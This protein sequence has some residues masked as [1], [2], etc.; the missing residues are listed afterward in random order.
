[1]EIFR[2]LGTIAID[3]SAANQALDDTAQRA[4]DTGDETAGAF[5]RIG[6]AAG[7]IAKGIGIAGAAIGGAM[8]A[9]VEG[10]R[11]Y[12]T[13]M[14]Q[15]DTAFQVAGHSSETARATFSELNAVLGDGGQATEAAQQL[16]LLTDSEKELDN[17]T[18]ILTG[19]YATFGESLPVEGLAEAANHTAKMGEVQGSLADALEWSG[20]SVDGFNAQLAECSTEQERQK[21][22]MDTLNGTYGKAS[23][24]YQETNKDI[25]AANRAQERLTN[26]FAELGQIGEPILTAIKN[27]VSEMVLVAVPH[28][29]NF[30]NKMRDLR[31][32]VQNN[33]TTI[34]GW[35]AA[36]IGGSVAVGAFLLILNWGAIMTAAANAVKTVRTA[37][38]AMNAAML[39]NP[40]ALIVALIAGL[41]AAFAYLWKNNEGFRKFVLDMWAKIRSATG[42][43]VDWIKSKFSVLQ[44]ALSTV[45]NVFGRIYTAMSDKITAAQKAVGKAVDKIKGFF[46]F[47][48][49]LP[50]IKMPTFS[51]TGKFSID[52]PSVPKISVRWNAEGAIL[53][54]ATIFG[55]AGGQLQGGGEDDPEAVAPIGL[56]QNYIRSAVRAENTEI[57]DT[58]ID[59]NR[60]MMDFLRHIIPQDVRL[61]TGALVGQLTPA[62]DM[63]LAD[64]LSHARRGNTR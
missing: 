49:S 62:V 15:L 53:R 33:Q 13:Q 31:T 51:A 2:I 9:A 46:N 8:I 27:K 7:A 60:A 18:G 35:I 61:D 50:K 44:S 34:D 10:T 38:L 12:R 5:Q 64:R 40:I 26:A 16:A 3:N 43:A 17:W 37:I 41:V 14:G 59:Q 11:E 23:E 47:K 4:R 6:A 28:I 32:W 39:A 22:I 57:R 55:M 45:Q 56:L 48:W 52:P 21:L 25:L 63:R 36:I 19:V 24:Q 54:K 58:I 1:M 20:I 30:V 29:E 42:T